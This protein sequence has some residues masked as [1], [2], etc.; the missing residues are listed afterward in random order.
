[1]ITMIGT[2]LDVFRY[3]NMVR[4]RGR[5]HPTRLVRILRSTIWLIVMSSLLNA[6]G[7]GKLGL[8]FL[9]GPVRNMGRCLSSLLLCMLSWNSPEGPW[10]PPTTVLECRDLW[11]W[12]YWNP[13]GDILLS[14]AWVKTTLNPAIVDACKDRG[15]YT[16]SAPV[17]LPMENAVAPNTQEDDE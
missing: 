12:P 11:G 15:G 8:R 2:V 16:E 4:R 14:A 5:G 9:H 7:V 10:S 1:M 17:S 6:R 13:H 3:M